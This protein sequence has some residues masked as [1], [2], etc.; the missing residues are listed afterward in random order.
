MDGS[1]PQPSCKNRRVI[2]SNRGKDIDG[3]DISRYIKKG[4]KQHGILIDSESLS[5]DQQ[6]KTK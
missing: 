1:Q 5:I 2:G 4:K 3:G 6:N